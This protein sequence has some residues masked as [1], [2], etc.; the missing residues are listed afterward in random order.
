MIVELGIGFITIGAVLYALWRLR[1]R[2]A[3]LAVR[4]GKKTKKLK[5]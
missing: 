2:K 3:E 1:T 4:A 5:S